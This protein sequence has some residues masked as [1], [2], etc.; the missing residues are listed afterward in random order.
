[1]R[2]I[3]CLFRIKHT[4]GL[5]LVVTVTVTVTVMVTGY[6]FV[7]CAHLFKCLGFIISE[8]K[9]FWLRLNKMHVMFGMMHVS[10]CKT[11][12]VNFPYEIG[13]IYEIG[14]RHLKR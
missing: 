5:L 14:C 11:Q 4:T 1:M 9:E 7:A 12:T 6:L 10:D 8:Q 13:C 3:L 2:A